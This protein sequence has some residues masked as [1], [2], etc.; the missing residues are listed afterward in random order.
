MPVATMK[1]TIRSPQTRH[2]EVAPRHGTGESRCGIGPGYRRRPRLLYRARARGAPAVRAPRETRPLAGLPRLPPIRR[3]LR[4]VMARGA[5][6]RVRGDPLIVGENA[7][8][9]RLGLAAPAGC[10]RTRPGRR[11]SRN[12]SIGAVALLLGIR[13]QRVRH[14]RPVLPVA[15]CRSRPRGRGR[16]HISARSAG[17]GGAP[18]AS[19]G[20]TSFMT[21]PPASRRP[22]R[23]VARRAPHK[24][25]S[26]RTPYLRGTNNS[27]NWAMSRRRTWLPACRMSGRLCRGS[28]RRLARPAGSRTAWRA[29]PRAVGER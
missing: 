19:R 27:P 15:A 20:V 13:A 4:V 22:D 2:H 16:L 25:S 17:S 8:G 11:A 9:D 14:L 5:L 28:A 18:G 21:R 10:R 1:S 23:R 7:A 12:G 6:R 24:A 29:R 26:L 3:L